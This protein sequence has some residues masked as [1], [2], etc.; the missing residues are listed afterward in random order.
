MCVIWNHACAHQVWLEEFAWT[1]DEKAAKIARRNADGPRGQELA[2]QPMFCFES[3]MKC[4]YWASLCY[5]YREVL[6]CCAKPGR[7]SVMHQSESQT[8]C[9]MPAASA[10]V[11]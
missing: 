11:I 7:S 8:Y 5:D 2:G 3:A 6:S 4:L 1:E 10:G 9:P